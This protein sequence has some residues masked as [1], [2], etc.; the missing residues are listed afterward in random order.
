[1]RLVFKVLL[2]NTSCSTEESEEEE[3]LLAEKLVLLLEERWKASTKLECLCFFLDFDVL[4]CVDLVFFLNG[5][6]SVVLGGFVAGEVKMF[7]GNLIVVGEEGW[8]I[9]IEEIEGV[10]F[11]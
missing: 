2:L 4:M 9:L 11:L 1:M 7:V 10:V 6:G 3:L 8:L 5:V